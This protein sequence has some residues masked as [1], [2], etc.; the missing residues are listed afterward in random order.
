MVCPTSS[1]GSGAP[2]DAPSRSVST[3]SISAALAGRA[4]TS[5][6]RQRITICSSAA[7]ISRPGSRARI[8][9]GSVV[10]FCVMSATDVDA[11]CVRAPVS[12]SYA[13]TPSA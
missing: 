9:I 5:R 4:A 8:G 2:G 13:T 3:R 7:G 12:I 1:R 11:S 10:S 6:A